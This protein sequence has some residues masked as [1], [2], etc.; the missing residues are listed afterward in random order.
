MKLPKA[1]IFTLLVS[2]AALMGGAGWAWHESQKICCAFPDEPGP[3]QQEAIPF[4]RPTLGLMT[5][6]PLYWPL[7][8]D[9][10]DLVGGGEVPWQRSALARSHE[11]VLLD[12][13]SP[14]AGLTPDTAETDPLAEIEYLAIIQP[15]GLSP[16]DNVALDA[17]VRA[18]GRLLLVLDPQLTGE[19]ELPLGDPRRPNDIALNYPV[20]ARWGLRGDFSGEQTEI[21]YAELPSTAIPVLM[22]QE[23]EIDE[24]SRSGQ[25]C[26]TDPT[27]LIAQCLAIGEG[28]VTLLGD[29]AIFEHPEFAGP[30]GEAVTALIDFAFAQ[31]GAG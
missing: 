8:A 30:N 3:D 22:A 14:I 10:A 16:S 26:S 19:Y 5:S 11:L 1:N 31:Q 29:A 9:I 6:L 13:L 7:G 15:R 25:N 2:L 27:R 18:G 12:T 20:L 28:A 24:A 21:R 17:W 23:I 4:E